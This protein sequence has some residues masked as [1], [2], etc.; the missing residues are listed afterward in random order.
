MKSL[1]KALIC[2]RIGE[3]TTRLNVLRDLV[4]GNMKEQDEMVFSSLLSSIRCN[5]NAIEA[6][7][8]G[9]KEMP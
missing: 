7:C 6:L 2:I 1:S 4:V 5:V 3:V 8:S 9:T